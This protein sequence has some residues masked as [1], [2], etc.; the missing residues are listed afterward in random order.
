[1]FLD[2]HRY[3]IFQ[4]AILTNKKLIFPQKLDHLD[5]HIHNIYQLFPK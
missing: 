3:T 1:M 4:L 2:I 5:N